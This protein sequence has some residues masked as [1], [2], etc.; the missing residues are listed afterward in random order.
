MNAKVDAVGRV[1]SDIRNVEAA[2]VGAGFGGLCMAIKLQ[3]AGI[4]DFVILEKHPEDVGGTWRDNTYPGAACDVQSHLYSY[5]FEGNPDW[6]MRYPGWREIRDYIERTT[7]KY[8]IRRYVQFDAEVVAAEFNKESGRWLVTL[9][10][11][12]Q[13]NARYFILA[14]GP[15]HVPHIPNF[16]GLDN[17]KGEAFHSAQWNHDFDLTGKRVI[18]IGTG[19]SAIQ[20]APE[21][22]PKVNKLTLFQ[23]TPAWVIPRD[24]RKYSDFDKRLFK[25]FPLMRKLHRLRLYATN[26][27]RVFPILHSRLAQTFQF[28]AGSFLKHQ[29]KDRELRKKLTPN[30]TI[31]CKRVLISNAY[32]PMFNRDNVELVTEGIKEIR[33]HSVVDAQGVEHPADAIIFGTGFVT[34]PRIYMK[35]FKLTGLPG[36]SI[37]QDWKE[38]AEAYYGITVSGY[39]NMFQLVGPNTGLGHNSVIFMIENQVEYIMKCLQT[40]EGTGASYMDLKQSAQTKFNQGLQERLKGTVWTSGCQSWYQQADGRNV[41]IWPGTTWRY[42]QELKKV[43]KA[44]Y[45]WVSLSEYGDADMANSSQIDSTQSVSL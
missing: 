3:E 30:Y 35:D 41:V 28:I 1:D 39:P 4:T 13:L 31:G 24:M 9:A 16:P 40:M 5:S 43:D 14:T 21:I 10:D 7:D 6:S 22:A 15:L 42:Q 27:A 8:G 23:R 37:Q 26:E 44:A 32:Y 20:Y 33:E 34:D 25:R 17:F 18:S 11:G 2:I 45:D 29:I 36:H 12:Q 19:G 38:G